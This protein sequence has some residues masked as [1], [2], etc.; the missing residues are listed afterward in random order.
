MLGPSVAAGL[1]GGAIGG[2]VGALLAI[3]ASSFLPNLGGNVMEQ[4][5]EDLAQGRPVD[6]ET[7][8]AILYSSWSSGYRCSS[9]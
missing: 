7:G 9:F 4:A 6:I 2:P 8:K 3:A 5:A 1:A